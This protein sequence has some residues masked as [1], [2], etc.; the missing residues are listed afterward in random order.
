MADRVQG[1]AGV[2]RLAGWCGLTEVGRRCGGVGEAVG[3][4][5]LRV[6][7]GGRYNVRLWMGGGGADGGWGPVSPSGWP[8]GRGGWAEFKLVLARILHAQPPL[9]LAQWAQTATR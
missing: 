2:P 7:V 4:P 3:A 6:G 9:P 5:D 1:C 8:G